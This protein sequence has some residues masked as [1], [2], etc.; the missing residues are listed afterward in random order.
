MAPIREEGYV[1][2]LLSFVLEDSWLVFK[3][4][5]PSYCMSVEHMM[6]ENSGIG[7]C[8]IAFVSL[9]LIN[10]VAIG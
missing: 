9:S 7:W 8:L 10:L 3:Q 5:C 4:T 6:S 2:A 1:D